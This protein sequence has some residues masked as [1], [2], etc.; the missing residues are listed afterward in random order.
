MSQPLDLLKIFFYVSSYPMKKEI[1]KQHPTLDVSLIDVLA[2]IDPSKTNKYLPF[3]IKQVNN[4]LDE[5]NKS[6]KEHNSNKVFGIDLDN[7]IQLNILLS[8]VDNQYVTRDQLQTLQIFNEL[9]EQNR[10]EENDITK[11]K[12]FDQIQ[13]AIDESMVKY[14]YKNKEKGIAVLVDNDD[15]LIVRPLTYEAS[16]K[17]GANTK[18]CTASNSTSSQFIEYT[19]N[20]I[21]AYVINK[22]TYDKTAIHIWINSDGEFRETTF[23]NAKD[24]RIDSMESGIESALIKDVLHELKKV[25]I[26]NY[27]LAKNMGLP[28]EELEYKKGYVQQLEAPIG[29]EVAADPRPYY[30]EV[31]DTVAPNQALGAATNEYRGLADAYDEEMPEEDILNVDKIMKNPCC[32]IPMEASKD[33]CRLNAPIVEN[34]PS[35]IQRIRARV[36]KIFRRKKNI[37]MLSYQTR[38]DDEGVNQISKN[39][40]NS[41]LAKDYDLIV[42]GTFEDMNFERIARV[43][44]GENISRRG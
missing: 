33:M 24:S 44:N 42:F 3:L 5:L 30:G 13:K 20:G 11:Y 1:K 10:I 39:F 25:P 26:T 16:K 40:E 41:P 14:E 23:W 18:W 6:M 32:E 7:Y 9:L 8:I 12:D 19:Q 36:R 27:V 43:Q 28:L 15:Y 38:I 17:Y 2:K 22:K 37:L 29:V 21:L 4:R 34:Q 35:L 31:Q